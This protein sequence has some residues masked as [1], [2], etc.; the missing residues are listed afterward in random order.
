M[1]LCFIYLQGIELGLGINSFGNTASLSN[2]SVTGSGGNGG[3]EYV[4]SPLTTTLQNPSNV[5]LNTVDISLPVIFEGVT[6]GRAV[7][8]VSGYSVSQRSQD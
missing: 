7:I 2:V 5:S 6:I 1:P 3:T 4:V 8:D